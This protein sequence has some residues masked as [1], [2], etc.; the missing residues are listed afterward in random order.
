MWLDFFAR[1]GVRFQ[2]PDIFESGH[3]AGR[4]Q[5]SRG[6]ARDPGEVRPLNRVRRLVDEFWFDRGKVDPQASWSAQPMELPLP[7][8]S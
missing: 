1:S 6:V 8:P 7:V 2:A 4:T 3:F 5:L